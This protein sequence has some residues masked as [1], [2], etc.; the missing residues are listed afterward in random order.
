MSDR[1]IQRE[2]EA[3]E[4]RVREQQDVGIEEDV[5]RDQEQEGLVEEIL[6]LGGDEDDRT[7]EEEYSDN[8]RVGGPGA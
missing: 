8:T 1:D 4:R 5:L 2:I 3:N 6:D 7:E